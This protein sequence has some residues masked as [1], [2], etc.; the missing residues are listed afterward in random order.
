MLNRSVFT[1]GA[2]MVALTHA[3]SAHAEGRY[4][5]LVIDAQSKAVLHEDAADEQRYPASLTKMMTL[6]LLFEAIDHGEVGLFDSIS[7]SRNAAGQPPSRLGVRAGDQILVDDA[8]RALV[9][10]S[11]NDVAVAIAEHLAGSEARFAAR[12]TARAREIGM[13][14]TRFVNASGLPDSRQQT[15]ARDIATLSQALIEDYPQYYGYFQTPGMSWRRIYARNH[16]RLLGV[17]EGVDGIKT[18]YTNASG[19]NLAT[20]VSRGGQRL[21]AVVLGG[22]TALSRDNQMRYLIEQGFASLSASVE[23][24]NIRFTSLP[25]DRAAI[26][27][28]S[29]RVRVERVAADGLGL[30]AARAAPNS[31]TTLPGEGLGRVSRVLPLE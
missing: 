29:G 28:A 1:F 7:I 27:P 2:A 31:G 9:T 14:R 20:S 10:K 8:I 24:G 30:S 3:P 12:M 21:I 17:V 11:A 23:A 25:V 5:A 22:E 19:F 6:Y 16:N 13:G 18:G 15:T 26:D 4:A